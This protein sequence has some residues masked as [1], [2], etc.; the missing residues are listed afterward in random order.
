MDNQ[1]SSSYIILVEKISQ[2]RR[3]YYNNEII[4]GVLISLTVLFSVGLV[5]IVSEGSLRFNATTRTILF[6]AFIATLLGISFWYFFRPLAKLYQI[7]KGLNDYQISKIIG[8]HFPDIDDKLLNTIQL[9]KQLNTETNEFSRDLLL[10]S[11]QQKTN[12]LK[13]IPFGDAI[14]F[15]ENRKSKYLHYKSCDQRF[16]QPWFSRKE[17]TFRCGLNYF[18]GT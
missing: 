14:N 10:A 17:I 1:N 4:R 7:A 13:P 18:R 2:F 11:I 15:K 6:W 16:T 8:K 12:E 9:N 3:K 5:F